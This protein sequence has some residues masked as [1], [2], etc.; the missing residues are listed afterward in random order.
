[1]FTVEEYVGLGE[2]EFGYSELQEGRLHISPSPSKRHM[3]GS[4]ELFVQ[5]RSQVPADLIAIQDLDVDLGLASEA[6]PGFSRRPDLVV[7]RRSALKREG[8]LRASDVVVI[9]EIVSPGSK[10]TDRVVK[11]SE[12]SDVGIPHYWIVDL[13]E[14]VSLIAC[15]LVDGGYV[16]DGEVVDEFRADA[17]FPVRVDLNALG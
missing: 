5:L 6:E 14:P 1:M 4:G 10:R 8:M 2:F 7:A 9:V 17:P 12:Y 3:I 16:D 11:R 15:R 13:D